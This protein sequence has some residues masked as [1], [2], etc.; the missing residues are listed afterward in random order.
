MA[1]IVSRIVLTGGPC[2]GKTT[3]LSKIE[4]NLSELGYRVII[5]PEAATML[6]GGGIKC[7][8][9][10]PLSNYDFQNAIINLQLQNEKLFEQAALKYSSS[11]KCV[12]IYDRGT[13]DGA[14]YIDN[15]NFNKLLC[16]NNLSRIKLTDN[17]DMVIHLV[18][19]ADGAENFYTLA[20]NGARTETIEQARKLD[21]KTMEAWS[22]HT[23]LHIIDNST[24]FDT[25]MD[26]VINST[27]YVL[28]NN[29]RVRKQR[30]YLVDISLLSKY[31]LDNLIKVDIDQTYIEDIEYEK[32]LRK[33][34]I[35]G[36]NTY[37]YT[38][39]KKYNNGVSQIYTDRRIN[40]REY[41]E[42][43]KSSNVIG[44]ISKTRYSFINNKEQYRLDIF[45]NGECILET[46]EDASMILPFGINIL[47]DI[48]GDDNYNNSSLAKTEK[49]KILLPKKLGYNY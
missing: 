1:D 24:D 18:T 44:H 7:F 13:M 3:A 17:Y 38:V 6:I 47:Q 14:A 19:A 20:N 41:Y 39:Q 27:Y 26:R 30:K 43:L 25:K 36:E 34:T 4:R 28:G 48:T 46:N 2:A 40:E 8:G 21:K 10:N 5:V 32:R 15:N 31:F 37:Y 29:V 12:M 22:S 23:N 11:T 33:R 35:G 49:S 45:S 16:E 9:N 42:L